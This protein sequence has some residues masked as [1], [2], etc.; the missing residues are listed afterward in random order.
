M[1]MIIDCQEP[2]LYIQIGRYNLHGCVP[3]KNKEEEAKVTSLL[4][5]TPY[6]MIQ[7]LLTKLK[8]GHAKLISIVNY[9]TTIISIGPS[10]NYGYD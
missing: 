4:S 10:T 7:I 9:L 8:R 5:L 3:G 6:L 1:I 2:D